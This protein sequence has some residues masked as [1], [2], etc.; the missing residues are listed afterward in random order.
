IGVTLDM[1]KIRQ[2]IIILLL[3]WAIAIIPVLYALASIPEVQAMAWGASFLSWFDNL[4]LDV[5]AVVDTSEAGPGW[6]FGIVALVIFLIPLTIYGMVISVDE[7]RFIRKRSNVV[8]GVI[9]ESTLSEKVGDYTEVY[10]VTITYQFTVEGKVCTKT[11]TLS[12]WWSNDL[13][14][15]QYR[16]QQ[17]PAGVKISIRYEPGNL[18]NH[19]F[20]KFDA[21]SD[22]WVFIPLLFSGGFYVLFSWLTSFFLALYLHNF[23]DLAADRQIITGSILTGILIVFVFYTRWLYRKGLA[24]AGQRFHLLE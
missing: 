12:D 8:E 17:Y 13:G 23:P 21:R 5:L 24:S 22:A 15:H 20:Q 19:I 18:D 3:F 7:A 16:L 1:S 4:E 14:E 11:D 2:I 9:Q 10:N 6:E